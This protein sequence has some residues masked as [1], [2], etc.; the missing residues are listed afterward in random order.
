MT[1]FPPKL[2]CKK[3]KLKVL[4]KSK[5][6]KYSWTTFNWICTKAAIFNL[7][8]LQARQTKTRNNAANWMSKA[9][10]QNKKVGKKESSKHFRLCCSRMTDLSFPKLNSQNKLPHPLHSLKLYRKSFLSFRQHTEY[11]LVFSRK[12]EKQFKS[13]TLEALLI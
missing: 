9:L 3:F 13:K 7:T 6:Q 2:I 11:L 8:N 4:E 1:C 10:N 12:S 5:F